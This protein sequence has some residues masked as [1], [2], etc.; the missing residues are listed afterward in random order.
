MAED[1]GSGVGEESIAFDADAFFETVDG[2]RQSRSLNWKQV[3]AEAGV[4]QSTLTRLGQGRRPDV[5]SFARLVSWG[6]LDAD[7]F[8]IA[9]KMQQAGGFLTNLPTYLRSDPNLD[10]K[11]VHALETIIRAAYDQFRQS[12]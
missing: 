7:Q 12:S 2:E 3:A 9:P 4:S 10:D 5:D 1:T 8:V 6:G 11:G